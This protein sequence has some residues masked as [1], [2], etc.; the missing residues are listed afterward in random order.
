MAHVI[1]GVLGLLAGLRLLTSG[2]Q[3]AGS[4]RLR[5]LL[6]AA[7]GNPWR[8]LVA[9]CLAAALLHSSSAA[10]MLVEGLVR[11]GALSLREG[12]V[13]LMGANVGT[14]ATAHLLAMGGIP[15]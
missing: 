7:T 15:P 11:A 2:V 6:A 4:H 5:R 1:L 14:T 3:G 12:A 10:A 13:L 8:G 9:G